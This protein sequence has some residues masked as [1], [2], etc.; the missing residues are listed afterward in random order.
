MTLRTY[1]ST[2]RAAV[3]TSPILSTMSS[4][5]DPARTRQL[6]GSERNVSDPSGTG[7]TA[8]EKSDV[9]SIIQGEEADQ[10]DED[11]V[12]LDEKTPLLQGD[13][14]LL[15]RRK[16]SLPKRFVTT[17]I[18]NIRYIVTTVL[19]PGRY[20]IACFYDE[21]GRF[22]AALPVYRVRQ[23]LFRRTRRKKSQSL[24]ESTQHSQDD[25]LDSGKASTVSSMEDPGTT[26][27]DEKF[28]QDT[29]SR[30]TRSMSASSEAS[31]TSDAFTAKRSIRIK[32]EDSTRRRKR[33][34]QNDP[35]SSDPSSKQPALTINTIKSPTSSLSSSKL[36]K[37]PRAPAPP[38]PLIPKRSPSYKSSAPE[39]R[40]VE[41]RKTLIIDLDETLIHSMAKGG[42]MSTGHMVEVKLST[43][44]GAGGRIIGPQVPIL[45]YVHKRPYCDEFLRKVRQESICFHLLY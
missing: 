12:A 42:R 3:P 41:P 22:S 17:V 25:Q 31:E 6:A 1:F 9:D 39:I 32:T 4:K 16:Q 40:S 37:Y 27:I 24:A 30:H 35:N 38:R 14:E 15:S 10:E 44:V 33:R 34:E 13:T 18:D 19:T 11:A 23:K 26:I 2:I 8:M 20:V 21:K 43:S 29:P 5:E 7:T 28:G 45:Y 36:T